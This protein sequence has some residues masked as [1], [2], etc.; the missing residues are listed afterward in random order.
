MFIKKIKKTNKNS[1]KVYTYYRLV[2]SYRTPNGPRHKTILNLGCPD[3]KDKEFKLLADRIEEIMTGT[4]RMVSVPDHIETL[5]RHYANRILEENITLKSIGEK[6]ETEKEYVAVDPKSTS[7]IKSRSIGGEYI[8][9]KALEEIQ[10]CGYLKDLGFTEKQINGLVLNIIGRLLYPASENRTL[11]WGRDISGLSTLL[12]TDYKRYGKNILYRVTDKLYSHKKEV[13]SYMSKASRDLF[14]LKEHIILY[15]LTNTFFEG[16]VGTGRLK[17]YGRS[18][19]KRFGSPLVTLGLVIDENGFP[20][21]SR[22]FRGNASEPTTLKAMLEYLE[23]NVDISVRPTIVMD[24]GLSSEKNLKMIR[25]D[26]KY[27]YIVVSRKKTDRYTGEDLIKIK[28]DKGGRIE[29]HLYRGDKENILYCKSRKKLLKE[30]SIA[31]KK[32]KKFEEDLEKAKS[33]LKKKYGTKSYSKVL[34]RIGRIKERHSKVSRFYDINIESNDNS[35]VT[36]LTYAVKS[37]ESMRKR[38]SGSYYLRTTRRDLNEKEIWEIY[39]LLT[40][41]E[42]SFRTMKSELGLRPVYHR[43]DE[44]IE[45]HLFITVVAY[46]IQRIIRFK[47]KNQGIHDSWDSIRLFMS[48]H[49]VVDITQNLEEGGKL[50][51]R[52]CSFPESYH[53]KIY[54]ALNISDKPLNDVILVDKS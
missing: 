25:E 43:T 12:D 16:G 44:R 53:R 10:F 39:V 26:F 32:R 19:E 7:V 37:E 50:S 17:G 22:V 3:I 45:S 4:E 11:E 36:D 14:S 30:E 20:K 41:I 49:C 18:K 48:T 34:E 13:E 9:S 15:D 42:S 24:A 51:I 29:A 23:E 52:K 33:G 38:F 31:R 5:A 35:I 40:D 28:E 2:E 1:D 6:K 54:S 21:C 47:L 46:H 27:D 8:V